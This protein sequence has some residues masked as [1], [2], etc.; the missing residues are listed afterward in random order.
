MRCAE[1]L[2]EQHDIVA[3]PSLRELRP[4]RRVNLVYDSQTIVRFSFMPILVC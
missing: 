4:R 3:R 1:V 2:I